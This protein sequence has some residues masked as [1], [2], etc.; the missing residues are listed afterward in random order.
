MGSYY[1]LT[2]A[3]TGSTIASPA[4]ITIP[5]IGIYLV[6]VYIQVGVSSGTVGLYIPVPNTSISVSGINVAFSPAYVGYQSANFTFVYNN[7]VANN[8]YA[9]GAIQGSTASITGVLYNYSYVRIG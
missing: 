6:M 1:I 2:G 8:T 7:T 4:P 9:I 5:S 3:S